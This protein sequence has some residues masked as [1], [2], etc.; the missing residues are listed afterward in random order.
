M[1]AVKKRAVT[2]KWDDTLNLDS[3]EHSCQDFLFLSGELL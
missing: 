2:R 3:G 1:V